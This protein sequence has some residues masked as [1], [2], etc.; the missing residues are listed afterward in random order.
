MSTA[1][2]PLAAATK[3]VAVNS[4]GH[5]GA[6]EPGSESFERWKII[7][8][9]EREYPPVRSQSKPPVRPI[10][11]RPPQRQLAKCLS[12]ILAAAKMRRNC[13]FG[14]PLLLNLSQILPRLMG[15]LQKELDEFGARFDLPFESREVFR[16]CTLSCADSSDDVAL[17]EVGKAV[18]LAWYWKPIG[19]T[20]SSASRQIVPNSKIDEFSKTLKAIPSLI[21]NAM[22]EH[23][24]DE[25]ETRLR[26]NDNVATDPK[27]K[28][29]GASSLPIVYYKYISMKNAW[30]QDKIENPGFKVKV[31][32]KEL[33]CLLK[34]V[35]AS[36]NPLEEVLATTQIHYELTQ[37]HAKKKV[38]DGYVRKLFHNIRAKATAKNDAADESPALTA[39][40]KV[41]TSPQ[42]R[43]E[44]RL[45][46]AKDL[47]AKP[48]GTRV[49]SDIQSSTKAKK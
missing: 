21:T 8:K 4:H 31:G 3:A 34:F 1:K 32:T 25:I 5:Y 43:L 38:A 41:G 35:D 7:Q 40:E 22:K 44:F 20:R 13:C 36:G 11:P 14:D 17:N 49:T 42:H 33:L 29:D 19:L 12:D 23:L 37:K 39:L 15:E 30:L 18:K 6:P 27:A 46:S 16:N 26:K 2:D 28:M 45:I 47:S 48:D 24:N 9:L 10:V